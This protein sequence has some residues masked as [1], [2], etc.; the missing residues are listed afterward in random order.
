MKASMY[1]KPAK[2]SAGISSKPILINTHEVAHRKTTK[3]ATAIDSNLVGL[4]F[5]VG[6]ELGMGCAGEVV[7]INPDK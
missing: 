2:V 4:G 6:D 5:S 1:R 3:R 7:I